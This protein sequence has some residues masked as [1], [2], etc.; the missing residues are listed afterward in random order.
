MLTLYP[1]NVA[2]NIPA[3]LLKQITRT[4]LA[5]FL[6][7]VPTF[8][9]FIGRRPVADRSRHRARRRRTQDRILRLGKIR[10]GLRRR[11]HLHRGAARL[12]LTGTRRLR[13]EYFRA[14]QPPWRRECCARDLLPHSWEQVRRHHAVAGRRQDR[15]HPPMRIAQVGC[16]CRRRNTGTLTGSRGPS[17]R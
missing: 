15:N 14:P 5:P 2:E 1:K 3:H 17:S 13:L 6:H 8:R 9:H 4:V 16:P 10:P 7:E 11:E 12:R